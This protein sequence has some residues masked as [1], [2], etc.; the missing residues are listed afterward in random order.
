[1][2]QVGIR[3]VTQHN[4]HFELWAH[5]LGTAISYLVSSRSNVAKR[6]VASP[7]MSKFIKSNNIDACRVS[8]RGSWYLT[9]ALQAIIPCALPA[10]TTL[11]SAASRISIL[12]CSTTVWM[13][14]VDP[15]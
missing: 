13:L 15:Q 6:S 14:P 11:V 4:P 8:V 10:F 3:Q 1:M 2:F 9:N 5:A 12:R 7:V